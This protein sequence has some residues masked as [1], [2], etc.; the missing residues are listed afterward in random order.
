M[1]YRLT[2]LP[3]K[4]STKEIE[5]LTKN[6]KI[7]VKAALRDMQR[8]GPSPEGR[9]ADIH[10]SF[11]GALLLLPFHA[12]DG[13]VAVLEARHAGLDLRLVVGSEA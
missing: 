9:H 5:G 6:L 11:G 12:L 8:F 1:P 7:E 13:G 4:V 2:C 10:E 3:D